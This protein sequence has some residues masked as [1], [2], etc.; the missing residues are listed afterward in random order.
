[1]PPLFS[2]ES[3]VKSFG[4]RT[5]LKSA[6]IWA[7]P[8]RVTVLLGRNGCGKSTLLKIGAGL[9]AADAGAVH[10]D[11]VCHVRPRLHRLA[12]RGLFYLPQRD[13]LSPR[14]TLRE[15]LSA[16]EWRF[17]KGVTDEALAELGLR[18]RLDQRPLEMSGGECRRAEVAMAWIRRPRCLLADEPFLGVNPIAAETVARALRRMA[19][20][21]CAVLVTGHE[22]PQ[23]ME[24]ADEVVWMVA[25]T[26]HG[27]GTPEEA[28]RHDQF[29][30]D[31]L[32]PS[33]GAL[34]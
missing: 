3:A 5:V 15:H 17:G 16:L 24:I 32:G 25:G 2:V 34:R 1:M 8:G 22:V 31:Y 4:D 20:R 10:F 21:G 12:A 7:A 27:V 29:V 14:W 33:M 11:G 23:L 9:L 26:T 13:L 30:R 19:D 28:A 18:E 6:S